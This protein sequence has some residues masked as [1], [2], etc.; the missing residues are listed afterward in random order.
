MT[1]TF[2]GDLG[3]AVLTGL[4]YFSANFNNKNVAMD[5]TAILIIDLIANQ[6]VEYITPSSSE[7]T[8]ILWSSI[9]TGIGMGVY[10]ELYGSRGARQLERDIV[11]GFTANAFSNVVVNNFY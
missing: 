5:A 7:D 9:A 3:K 10:S 4:T 11:L 6:G 1:S 2:K 8:K